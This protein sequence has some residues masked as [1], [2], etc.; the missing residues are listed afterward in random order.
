MKKILRITTVSHSLDLLLKGQLK[1]VGEKG[2]D[3]HIACSQDDAVLKIE[4]R[5]IV[6]YH[7]LELTRTLSPIK[8]LV[9]LFNTILLIRKIKPD[10][11]HSHSPKAGIVG[12]LASFIC[13]VPLKVHTV[14]GLPLT[15]TKGVK[16]W[17]LIQVERLTYYCSDFVL[18]NSVNQKKYI[19]KKIYNSPKVK[20]IGK[21]SS[22]GVDLEYFNSFSVDNNFIDN[23]KQENNIFSNDIVLCF[24][25]RL[26]YYKGV[27]ELITV[28]RKL[29]KKHSNIKLLLVGPLEELNPLEKSTLK[30]INE[31]VN[32]ISLG[33]QSDI[34]P[35][36]K[37]SD[38][39]VFPSY[40]EGFP[41]SLMQAAAM[42]LACIA[43]DINGC[44]EILED[45]ETG[46]LIEPKNIDSLFSAV[47]LLL[48]DKE[49]RFTMANKARL[50]MEE[51]YEQ[52]KFW[53]MIVAFYN[54]KSK[55]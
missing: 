24:V 3:F 16:K 39:F 11:V 31:N 50:K 5:E 25:G 26:T 32:I 8:D 22:N 46:I 1:Y 7:K 52:K 18:S 55:I 40:R 19:L 45:G 28:F 47:D 9:S 44:N 23:F 36:L 49:L 42:N 12:M 6:K 30:E 17:V 41:Q 33:H 51:F 10:I 20:I 2:F 38:I 27:N 43:T 34:R 4:K 21:G 37:M 15:E 53:N 35:Y 14:A 13:N 54:E 29:S 48:N